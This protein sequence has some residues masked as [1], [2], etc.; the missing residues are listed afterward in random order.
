MKIKKFTVGYIFGCFAIEF[1][2]MNINNRAL[3]V[4]LLLC[5]NIA[6]MFISDALCKELSCGNRY[7]YC[8]CYFNRRTSRKC[9]IFESV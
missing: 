7:I 9:R 8:A 1:I 2:Q 3:E 6:R 5:L 4:F